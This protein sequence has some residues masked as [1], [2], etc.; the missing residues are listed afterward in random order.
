M[1]HVRAVLA[2]LGSAVS[3]TAATSQA[4]GPDTRS[5]TPA[6][7]DLAISDTTISFH[8]DDASPLFRFHGA[9]APEWSDKL[10]R[11][12]HTI[13]GVEHASVQLAVEGTGVVLYGARDPPLPTTSAIGP[14]SALSV[15]DGMGRLLPPRGGGDG[16]LADVRNSSFDSV[17]ARIEREPTA[18]AYCIS[19]A[20]VFT[21][22]TDNAG[23]GNRVHMTRVPFA[24]RGT[25]NKGFEWS[26]NW[27]LGNGIDDDNMEIVGLNGATVHVPVPAGHSFVVVRGAVGPTRGELVVEWEP[28]VEDERVDVGAKWPS[29]TTLYLRR[30]DPRTPHSLS[31]RANGTVGLHSV[32]LYSVPSTPRAIALAAETSAAPPNDSDQADA[33]FVSRILGGAVGGVALLTLIAVLRTWWTRK[34]RQ[35]TEDAEARAA[36]AAYL[37]SRRNYDTYHWAGGDG[38][39]SSSTPTD[40]RA[41]GKVVHYGAQPGVSGAATS[42]TP[43]D[44]YGPQATHTTPARAPARPMPHRSIT[45]PQPLRP[46]RSGLYRS[47]S[48]HAPGVSILLDPMHPITPT[49]SPGEMYPAGT[50]PRR[51]RDTSSPGF[52]GVLDLSEA[53]HRPSRRVSF[54]SGDRLR[55]PR[56]AMQSVEETLEDYSPHSPVRRS[57][58]SRF[59]D[60]PISRRLTHVGEPLARRISRATDQSEQDV[61]D[62]IG[63]APP[64]STAAVLEGRRTSRSSTDRAISVSE[65]RARESLDSQRS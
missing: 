39:A 45:S 12:V 6:H 63:I 38:V 7:S 11:Q 41:H 30:L 1:R 46:G 65:G 35:E 52:P 60:E 14:S 42:T 64:V 47:S 15:R 49:A 33:I 8:L 62:D 29:V 21:D 18:A 16:V 61:W 43:D 51:E 25:V 31:L 34:K 13:R 40:S 10:G 58:L 19:G 2:L 32:T 50:P 23:A 28:P 53:A 48:P 3:G 5:L 57:S 20:T 9:W 59:L 44:R 4:R 22:I 17:E 27:A 26:G 55:P 36:Y 56:L 24:E 37:G 54:T